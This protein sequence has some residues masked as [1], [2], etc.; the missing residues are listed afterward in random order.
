MIEIKL[1]NSAGFCFGVSKAVNEALQVQ[2]KYNKKIYTL[3]PL[4][5]NNDVVKYLEENNI[6]SISLEEIDSLNSGDVIVI[7]SHGVS[8][9]VFNLLNEKGLEVVNGTCPF[10]TNIQKKVKKYSKEGYHI[11]ILGDKDHPEVIGIN[12][13]CDNKAIIT[14]DGE[15]EDKIPQKV[16][17]VSQT[18]EKLKTGKI[19]LKA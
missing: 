19:H 12:G 16:C 13:W 15:F 14:K 2:K 11:V 8:E 6:Y 7:R 5:H 4:I 18:T 9:S 3:G 17:L 10:V 1:A